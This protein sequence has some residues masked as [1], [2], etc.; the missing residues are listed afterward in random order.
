M[1]PFCFAKNQ[2]VSSDHA[3]VHP[4]DIGLIRGYAIFD[5]FRTENFQP[6]FLEEYLNRF[7]SSAKGTSLPLDYNLDELK[8]I[9]HT[10]IEKNELEQGGIRMLLSGGISDNNF[11]PARGSLF[12]FCEDLLMPSAEK[13]QK[14]IKLL[15]VEYVRP[16]ATIKTTNYTLPAWLSRGWKDEGAE[17]VI[18]HYG[19]I[20]SESSRSNIFMVKAGEISTPKANILYGITRKNVIQ[21]AGN[22]QEK[23]ISF[24]ELLHADEVFI[25]STTKRILP[26]TQIDRKRIGG[27]KPGLVT[28][29]L[30]DKFKDLEIKIKAA[31]K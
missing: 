20:I 3:S 10:L 23:D 30:I 12:I 31:V 8:N 15:S 22:V 4:L 14:G 21:L 18:Y 9:V 2:V 24:T 27:G 13:Y 6:F 1:K 16:L 28:Q 29:Q 17:D 25:T 5:F 7:I 26:V 19:G 11:S